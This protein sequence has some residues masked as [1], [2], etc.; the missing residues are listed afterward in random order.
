LALAES[1]LDG[2]YLPTENII[3]L[4]SSKE[5]IVKEGIV[6]LAR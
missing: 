2:G 3:V 5:K 1:L 4:E 6:E